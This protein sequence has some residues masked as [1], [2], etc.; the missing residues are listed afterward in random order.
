MGPTHPCIKPFSYIPLHI[1]LVVRLW[2]EDILNGWCSEMCVGGLGGMFFVSCK[3]QFCNQE[4]KNS[5][6]SEILRFFLVVA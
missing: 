2:L 5:P 1:V 3:W 6:I 4:S